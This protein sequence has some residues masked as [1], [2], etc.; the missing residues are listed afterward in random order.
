[1]KKW[2][3]VRSTF[4]AVFRYAIS[5]YAVLMQTCH[6]SKIISNFYPSISL[7]LQSLKHGSTISHVIYIP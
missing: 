4:H 7:L 1:M 2:N 3:H 5:I 6:I